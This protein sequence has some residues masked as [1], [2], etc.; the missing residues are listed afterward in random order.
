MYRSLPIIKARK[1]PGTNLVLAFP[2]NTPI[3]A[4]HTL[5]APRRC[6]RTLADLTKEERLEIL[7]MAAKIKAALQKAVASEGFNCVCNEG[8][9]AGQSVPHFHLHIIPRKDGDTGI[10]WYDTSSMPYR[11]GDR[12]P[13]VDEELLRKRLSPML[14]GNKCLKVEGYRDLPDLESKLN[15]VL[16]QFP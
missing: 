10:L 8:K 3:S 6:A 12:E 1:I 7:E 2:T 15:G 9:L 11:T 16:E 13:T 4:G 14:K 5:I